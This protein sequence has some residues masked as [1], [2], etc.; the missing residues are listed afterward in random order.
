MVSDMSKSK[1]FDIVA[2]EGVVAGTSSANI[3]D[4][5]QIDALLKKLAIVGAIKEPVDV[6][7]QRCG[8]LIGQSPKTAAR[9]LERLERQGL[10]Q[11]WYTGARSWGILTKEGRDVLFREYMDYQAIFSGNTAILVLTGEVVSGLGEGQYYTNLEGYRLQFVEKLGIDPFPGTL[12]VKLDEKSFP[13]RGKLDVGGILIEGFET[14][15][16]TFGAARAY[17]ANIGDTQ[18][19]VVIPQRSH[20]GQDIIEIIAS[21]NL[22]ERLEL[23]D[24]SAVKL[25]LQ[26]ETNKMK[27]I[28]NK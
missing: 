12:N 27:G 10:L 23:K 4:S 16:R 22:R 25:E 7:I 5:P 8:E 15:D 28:T 14:S 9:R 13:L 21:C 18:C 20:H 11:R 24:G 3:K 17:I 1:S 19:G 26:L 6:S 2:S